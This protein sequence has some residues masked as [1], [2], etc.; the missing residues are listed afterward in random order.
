MKTK[1]GDKI[2][3][4]SGKDKGKKGLIL[5]V[6]PKRMMIVVDKVNIKKRHI[7]PR[8]EGSKGDI[9]QFPAPFSVSNVMLVCPKCTKA[10]RVNYKKIKKD[11]YRICK[12]CQNE[13]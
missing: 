7:K 5:R 1:K 12:K 13:F 10:T 2:V 6:F 11:K 3:V 8:K 4:I 9:I